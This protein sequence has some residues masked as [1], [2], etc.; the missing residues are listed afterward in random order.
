M[1]LCLFCVI[2]AR[3]LNAVQ[4]L[5]GRNYGRLYTLTMF[6]DNKLTSFDWL[7]PLVGMFDMT[8]ERF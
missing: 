8:K 5:V 6:T 3:F 2:D 4:K 7:V 1:N